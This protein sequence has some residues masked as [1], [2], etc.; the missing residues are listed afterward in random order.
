VGADV[1]QDEHSVCVNVDERRRRHEPTLPGAEP[2]A[3]QVNESIDA[4]GEWSSLLAGVDAKHHLVT[5]V[6]ESLEVAV[7]ERLDRFAEGPESVRVG[8]GGH[9]IYGPGVKP[10]HDLDVFLRHRLLLKPGGFEG[11]IVISEEIRFEDASFPDDV[12]DR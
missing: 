12:N 7:H 9:E 3:P 1:E 2:L 6:G 11:L 10:S 4:V 5:R 8:E